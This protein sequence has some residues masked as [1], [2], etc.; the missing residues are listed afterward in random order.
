MRLALLLSLGLAIACGT[1][2]A[3]VPE[4]RSPLAPAPVRRFELTYTAEVKEWPAGVKRLDLWVLLPL[5]TDVQAV[6]SVYITLPNDFAGEY[7]SP[8]SFGN[9]FIRLAPSVPGPFAVT[10]QCRVERREIRVLAPSGG[11]TAAARAAVEAS[12]PQDLRPD[13]LGVVDDRIRKLAQEIT[14]G[15][16]GELEQARATYDNVLAHMAYDKT[17]IGWGR[18]DTRYACDVGRGNCT[19]FH[20]LF[21]SLVRAR[22]IPARFHMGLS[23]PPHQGEGVLEGYHCWAE[24]WTPEHGWVPVDASEAWKHPERRDDLFGNLDADR[25][26]FSVGRDLKLPRMRGEPLS[27]I[28]G[29]YAEAD[30]KPF[31]GVEKRVSFREVAPAGAQLQADAPR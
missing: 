10:V 14:A 18:G 24:F 30:G 1:A 21:M 7:D 5:P 31:A 12:D 13:R 4:S 23:V 9:R 20:A 27:F 8:P 3:D 6:S 25:V 26:E 11:T 2:R 19:D 29:P 28:A 17:G 15:R 16:H 22:G